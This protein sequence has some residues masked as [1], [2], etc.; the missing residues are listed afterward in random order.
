MRVNFSLLLI[1]QISI[2]TIKIVVDW[3]G[4]ANEI[5]KHPTLQ[6]K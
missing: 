4:L 2:A 3:S 6:R 5:G 1:G